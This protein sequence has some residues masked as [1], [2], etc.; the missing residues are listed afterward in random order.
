M[1]AQVEVARIQIDC[2]RRNSGIYSFKVIT[3][4]P[5]QQE[6]NTLKHRREHTA[7]WRSF[8]KN[9]AKLRRKMIFFLTLYEIYNARS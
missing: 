4:V 5:L 6:H 8:V 9:T 1:A 7:D 3:D 2:Q